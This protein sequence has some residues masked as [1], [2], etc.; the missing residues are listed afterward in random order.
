MDQAKILF[1]NHDELITTA[2]RRILELETQKIRIVGA[3]SNQE[4][5][6]LLSASQGQTHPYGADF[7]LVF[8]KALTTISYSEVPLT[9]DLIIWLKTWYRGPIVGIS[10]NGTYIKAFRKAGCTH[11]I[12]SDH[13]ENSLVSLMKKI[14]Q[15]AESDFQRP[16][17][18]SIL[19]QTKS[20]AQS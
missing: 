16:F 5:R 3:V 4:A 20:A 14:G 2:A 15:D 17:L 1:V 11:V 8:I 6:T 7:D 13:H 9:L 19:D 10:T 18:P 12:R